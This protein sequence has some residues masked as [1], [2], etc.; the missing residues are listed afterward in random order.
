[1]EADPEIAARLRENLARNNFAQAIVEQKAVWSE[2]GSVSF[3]RVD[4]NASPDR[5]LG[6]VCSTSS[7]EA[8]QIVVEAVSLD[9]F[10]LS[11]PA[12]SLIKCDVEG[13][14]VAVVQGAARVLRESRP[15]L[16]IEMH[17]AENHALLTQ[18]LSEAGYTCRNLDDMH[19]LALPQ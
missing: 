14:E 8:D 12:T 3:A 10:T 5:G 1:F 2:V 19:V 6:H 15:I 9:E 4:P 18:K 7:G 17:S 11:H 13:A 16:L